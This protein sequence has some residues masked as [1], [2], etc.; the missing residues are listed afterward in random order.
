M[1]IAVL[2]SFYHPES[3]G[4]VN[5]IDG[6]YLAMLEKHPDIEV[7]IIALDT[8]KTKKY[9]EKIGKFNVH[10]LDCHTFLNCTYATPSIGGYLKLKSLLKN[11]NYDLINT[12][13]RF[14]LLSFLGIFLGKKIKTKTLHVE[15]GSGFVEHGNKLIELCAWIFDK[16]LGSYVLRNAA[17]VTGVSKSVCRFA[18]KLGAKKAIEIY[19]G[20]DVDF[21]KEQT[22]KNETRKKLNI[23]HDEIV[24]TFIGRLVPSKGC[25]DLISALGGVNTLPWKLLVIGDGFFQQDLEEL[26]RN[27]D[28]KERVFFLGRKSNEEIREILQ[29]TDLFVNPSFASEGMPTTVLEAVSSGCSSISSDRG[30]AVEILGSENTFPARDVQKLKEKILNY[31]NIKKSNAEEFDWTNIQEKFYNILKS[32]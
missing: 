5:Y 14:F 2:Q 15:H 32:D 10:R 12:H 26:V 31:K 19:N 18:E 4:V 29:I 1:K 23:S 30:G 8:Q 9:E 21:W 24:I 20:I 27:L 16:T 3:N 7:D 22:D 28:L 25:Q 17:V 11:G 13:T 6:L